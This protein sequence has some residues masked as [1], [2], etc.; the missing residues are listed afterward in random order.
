MTIA[1]QSVPVV[2]GSGQP[3]LAASTGAVEAMVMYAGES[4][5]AIREIA[6]AAEV[7]EVMCKDAERLLAHQ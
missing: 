2:K 4:V 5:A 7:I 1:G 3:P 6:P